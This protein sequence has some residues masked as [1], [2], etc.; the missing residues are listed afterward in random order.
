[1]KYDWKEV[2]EEVRNFYDRVDPRKRVEKK[3]SK[4]KPI[5]WVEGPPTLNNQPHI[6]HIRG[7]VYKDLWYRY[8]SMNGERLAFRGGWDTQGLP[9]ELEAE[10]A[11]GLTGNKWEN[12][13]QVGAERLV[14]AC[15]DL[16]S[17]YRAVWEE[18]DRLLGLHL[19]Q[20]RAY[21]TYTDAFIEREW[22]YLET[23]WDRGLLGEGY[24]VV[25]YCPSCLTALSHAEVALGGYEQ[26]EDPNLYYK[27]KAGDGSFLVI[28]TT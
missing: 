21:M 1:M 2:E 3:L 15:K 14:Q 12:L 10:K 25:A 4:K 8:S 9:V 11:L 16:I 19:D 6:G 5:G 13:R 20:K 24:K 27:V 23:A 18:S 7:R 17:K 26:L 28:W 22:K